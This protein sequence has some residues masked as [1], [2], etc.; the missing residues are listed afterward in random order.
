[1]GPP[2]R[3]RTRRVAGPSRPWFKILFLGALFI[4]LVA[5]S[6]GGYLFYRGQQSIPQQDGAARISGLTASVE[7]LRDDHGVT[8]LFAADVKD[9][10]RATGFV[11]GQDR[12]F[13][14]ELLRR[15]GKGAMAELF[16]PELVEHD[17]R[18]RRAGLAQAAVSELN[19]MTPEAREILE[20]YVA[21]VN[22][23]RTAKLE[24][25]PPEF[26]LLEH[27]PAPWEATDTLV[28]GKWMSLILS[29]NGSVELLRAN[30]VEALGLAAA[31]TLTGLVPPEIEEEASLPA[32]YRAASLEGHALRKPVVWGNAPGASNAWVV[33]GER[34]ASGRPLL[35][36]DPHLALSMPSVW[37]EMHLSGGG[38]DV[39][40]ASLPGVP[41]IW[42]GQNRR[43]A[44]G[45][46]ALYADVQDH[47]L[48]TVNPADTRQ[49]A[50][51]DSWARLDVIPETINVKGGSPVTE[52]VRIS[53][54]GTI[55]GES[56]DGR[57]IA[58][59][60]DAI[61]SGDHLL[62]VWKLNQAGSWQ[63]FTEALRNWAS[64]ALAFLYADVEGNIGFFPGGEIPVRVGFDGALPVDG[65]L[66]EYEWS[67][68][69]P[70]EM[71]PIIFNPEDGVIVSANHDM[72]APETPYPL[73]LD[74][75]S[76]FRADRIH[77]L[78]G[79][80][81]SL[82]LDDMARFQNDRYDM[83]TESILRHAVALQA[84]DDAQAR[85]L[86]LLRSWNGQM[87]RGAAPAIYQALYRSLLVNTFQDEMGEELFQQYL[88]YVESGHGG[89]L[90]AIIDDEASLFWDNRNTPEV[91]GRAEIFQKSMA[92]AVGSLS[93]ELGVDMDTWDWGMLHGVRFEHPLGRETPLSWLFSRGPI[94][95]GGSTYTIANAMVSLRQP[96]T[97]PAGTSFRLLADLD[98]LDRSRSVIPTG[99]SGHPFSPH[100]FD[101]NPEWV[102]GASHPLLMDRPAIESASESKLLL[103]P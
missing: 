38:I 82:T 74:T 47:Y 85:A 55:V 52:E 62:A 53:R 41:F 95:F 65:S 27:V 35:A 9:L 42:I 80:S 36:S 45:V 5:G 50:V 28:I 48:E 68:A 94:P 30:L 103:Q 37:Y 15:L 6:I 7:V 101:S 78:L 13:Q 19:R 34:S 25:L 71:K 21:G 83:S 90:Y 93:R 88:R 102:E 69:I 89:G 22:A 63:E 84:S 77:T 44:W 10:A 32:S 8:H 98:A 86:E 76:S 96:F 3:R 43:I 16:G 20:A 66:G 17:R 60:W 70:H 99:A 91:E 73:G 92:D 2:A 24:T 57:L 67:G 26:Q 100:Y 18:V 12:Y 14:M 75:L 39:A 61:W 54:H 58:Q 79:S 64:P 11:H 29:S 40:G 59:R 49:Y 23:Y 51:G 31:Y 72:L 4:L 46:T 97:A 87:A 56:S 81:R 1:M 33:S